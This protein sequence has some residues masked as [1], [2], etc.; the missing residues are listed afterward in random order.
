MIYDPVIMREY[1]QIGVRYQCSTTSQYFRSSATRSRREL[2]TLMLFYH[3]TSYCILY[4]V[5]CMN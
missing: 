1:C 4:Y 2:N 5:V 3:F